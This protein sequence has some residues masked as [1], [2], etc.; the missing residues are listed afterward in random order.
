MNGNTSN[1]V[2][3]PVAE[4]NYVADQLGRTCER[5]IKQ[6]YLQEFREAGFDGKITR[7]GVQALLAIE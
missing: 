7:H 6:S 5:R 3:V 2:D 4:E 1:F